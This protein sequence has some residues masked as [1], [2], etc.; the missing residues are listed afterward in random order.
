MGV[1]LLRACFTNLAPMEHAGTLDSKEAGLRQSPSHL[2]TPIKLPGPGCAR[3]PW[4]RWG[5]PGSCGVVAN[6]QAARLRRQLSPAPPSPGSASRIP[7]SA[8]ALRWRVPLASLSPSAPPL[9]PRP[10]SA[11]APA[12]SA[13][14]A[15]A[16][17]R[18]LKPMHGDSLA[19]HAR[20]QCHASC[21]AAVPVG[22]ASALGPQRLI[23][24]PA[25]TSRLAASL[26]VLALRP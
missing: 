8:V 25:A 23:S 18:T 24:G 4:R 21:P 14:R 22:H 9:S 3:H 20:R 12:P 6:H 16:S 15:F 19:R 2:Q 13:A 26:R 5:R 10:S 11:G 1:A 7:S 17:R